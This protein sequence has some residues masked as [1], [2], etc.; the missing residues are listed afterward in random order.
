MLR[1]GLLTFL[2]VAALGLTTSG[3]LAQVVRI[4]P[5]KPRIGQKL[6]VIYDSKVQGAKLS[7]NDEVYVIAQLSPYGRRII[8]KALRVGDVFKYEMTITPGASRVE[9]GFMTM[10]DFDRKARAAVMVYGIDGRPARGAH[11]VQIESHKFQE[12]FDKEIA[13]Y[14]DNY[15]AYADLWQAASRYGDKD[16]QANLAQTL[17]GDL[18]KLGKQVK[19][20]EPEYLYALVVGN[21]LLKQE[22]QARDAL[23]KLVAQ[24]PSSPLVGKAMSDYSKQTYSQGF[25]DG[26]KEIEGLKWDV[27]ARFPDTEFAREGL[28]ELIFDYDDAGIP[29]KD[30]PFETFEKI[31]TRWIADEPQN[32][33]PRLYLSQ[34]FLER[35][36]KTAL[37]VSLVEL[38]IQFLLEN[39]L[40]LY[41]G[42]DGDRSSDYLFDAYYTQ[43][44][45]LTHER[46]FVRAYTSLKAA[47]ALQR[48]DQDKTTEFKT[49]Y[50]EGRIWQGLGYAG[51]AEGSYLIAWRRGSDEAETALKAIYEKRGGK[52]EGFLEYARRKSEMMIEKE[53][54]AAFNV[55]S[56][57][58]KPLSLTALRGKMVVLNFW[59]IG[60][61][62]C[63]A[64][65]PGLNDLVREFKDKDV[66]FIAFASDEENE[67]REFLKRSRFDYQVAPNADEI[68]EL[69]NVRSYPT[70]IIID[71]NGLIEMR[72]TGGDDKTGLELKRML[73]R[74][75]D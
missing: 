26:L 11:Q 31:A 18:A 63:R 22:P 54:A 71:R 43:A 46:Q 58:G 61:A 33:R 53:R 19:G 45:L 9:V 10:D 67:L 29:V 4:D 70:H 38:A 51:R 49:Y 68:M 8:A 24:V 57:D 73:K 32:P 2:L 65:M 25:K 52:P 39:K 41:Y 64:E 59:F 5:E 13:L 50:L 16:A 62:P 37:G 14:P 28:E 55:T 48:D 15:A 74:S 36:Q 20:E 44:A 23:K 66:V 3:V 12:M 7:L 30:F 21:L 40:R 42:P 72:T 27:M 75:I 69:Y 17:Q 47:Q 1:F 56:L 60:C 6:T 35:K 34:F